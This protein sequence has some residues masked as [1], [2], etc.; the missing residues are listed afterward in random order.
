MLGN[1]GQDAVAGGVV[2]ARLLAQIGLTGGTV[3]GV[4][5]GHRQV[6]GMQSA[7]YQ[8]VDQRLVLGRK[9]RRGGQADLGGF[10]AQGIG[11]AANPQQLFGLGVPGRHLVIADRPGLG[12]GG[13]AG[14]TEILPGGEIAHEE[15]FADHAVQG[16]G[17]AGAAADERHEPLRG[18]PAD[19]FDLVGGASGPGQG[20][21]VRLCGTGRKRLGQFGYGGANGSGR[22]GQCR[23]ALFDEQHP[24]ARAG[25]SVA[26]HSAAHAGA[27]DD[28][29]PLNAFGLARGQFAVSQNRT[30][31]RCRIH[32][33][34]PIGRRRG[35]PGNRTA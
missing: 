9:R 3:V 19:V 28:H 12:H 27:H 7:T 16:R 29:V 20:V 6:V 35:G 31:Q 13:I 18:A 25:Q 26:Q 33:G 8:I 15:S 21:V 23:A 17:P 14:V 30:P 24:P 2:F 4:I 5:T 10:R 32:D 34:H 1:G 22:S 11:L